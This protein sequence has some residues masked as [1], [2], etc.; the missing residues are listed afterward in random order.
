MGFAMVLAGLGVVAW[1]AR[2]A[3]AVQRL[4]SGAA[5]ALGPAVPLAEPSPDAAAHKCLGAGAPLYTTAPCPGG[6][7]TPSARGGT[8][9]VV[10]AQPVPDEPATAQDAA[11]RAAPGSHRGLRA[12]AGADPEALAQRR[13]AHAMESVP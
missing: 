7:R 10:P 5:R 6:T 11:A 4:W 8:L 12:L 9:S 3:P 2:E 1:W 13:S